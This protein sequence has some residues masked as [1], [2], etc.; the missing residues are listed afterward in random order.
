[1]S[2]EMGVGSQDGALIIFVRN[3]IPGGV[4]TRLA[5]DIGAQKA[6]DVY[7]QLL[8]HTYQLT[9]T[10]SVRKYVYYSDFIPD[11]D[12]WDTD[13]YEKRTQVGEN[14][15]Q[16]MQHALNTVLGVHNHVVLIGSDA[17][18]LDTDT[19]L[20]SFQS[21]HFVDVVVGPATDGG[22]YLLGCK[23]PQLQIFENM[24]WS[25]Q[26]VFSHTRHL[27]LEHLLDFKILQ[28]KSDI[29]TLEDL[30]RLGWNNP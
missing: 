22:Y 10:L 6:E 25:T 30:Q 7:R 8:L 19:L 29:D 3:L 17:A 5:A 26:E 14:L 27:L 12:I 2:E 15:G 21:L 16:R 4:K 13:C 24:A 18:D 9:K 11:A 28:K 1:M 20:E 23:K